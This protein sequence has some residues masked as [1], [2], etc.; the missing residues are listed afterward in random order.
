MSGKLSNVGV[1]GVQ[2]P[3]PD[4]TWRVARK[5]PPILTKLVTLI[6]FTILC[7]LFSLGVMLTIDDPSTTLGRQEP[8]YCWFRIPKTVCDRAHVLTQRLSGERG[9]IR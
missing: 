3:P 6:L 5:H 9:R 1:D 2:H 4:R 7:L 8:F